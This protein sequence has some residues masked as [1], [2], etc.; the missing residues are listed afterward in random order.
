[1]SLSQLGKYFLIG[2]AQD[3]FRCWARWV[4]FFTVENMSITSYNVFTYN[5][6]FS[7][8]WGRQE[9]V[10]GNGCGWMTSYLTLTS[11]LS[12]NILSQS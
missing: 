1:M 2:L 7:T 11:N 8:F 3:G 6:M 5:M 12:L 9:L 4:W 10:D